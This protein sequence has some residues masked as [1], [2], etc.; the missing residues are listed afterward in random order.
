[1]TFAYDANNAINASRDTANRYK[2][3]SKFENTKQNPFSAQLKAPN[4]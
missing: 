4:K 2:R 1:M 3:R